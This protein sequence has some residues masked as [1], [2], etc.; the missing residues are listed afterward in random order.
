MVGSHLLLRLIRDNRKVKA[1]YREE[2]SLANVKKVF[3]YYSENGNTLFEQINWVRADITDIPALENA[4]KNVTIV[5][6]AAAMISF[7]PK[8][9]YK[10]KA[11]NVTG[12]TNIVNLCI[13]YTIKKLC[14]VSTIGAIGRSMNGTM[15]TEENEW[16]SQYANVYALTK[17]R[18]E[19]EVWRGSQEGLSVIIVNP[20]VII[21]PGFWDSGSGAFFTTAN[22]GYGFYPPGGTGFISVGDVVKMMVELMHMDIGNQRF[23]AITEN[24]SYKKV[25]SSISQHLG[26]KEPTR[27]LKIWQL[28]IGRFF[29]YLRNQIDGK[30]RR[31]TKKSIESLL[32][33]DDYDNQKIKDTLDFDF[34]PLDPIISFCC[35]KFI[36]ENR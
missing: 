36:E 35:Q 8:N 33:R 3:S 22:K 6:H 1:I 5:Y 30:G 14:Y 31:I 26:K 23:I 10:L 25:L 12:T 11:A 16:A 28:Q 17:Y 21:G 9:Y 4:F 20:G 15:A 2:G 24:L 13:E 19:M 34:E 27:E 32:H 7:D 18:A 29:D